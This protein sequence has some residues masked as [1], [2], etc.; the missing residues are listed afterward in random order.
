[1]MWVPRTPKRA[2]FCGCPP[3]PLCFCW[4]GGDKLM[5][6]MDKFASDLLGRD[7]NADEREILNRSAEKI[8]TGNLSRPVEIER[9]FREADE[10]RG[11]EMQMEYFLKQKRI[12]AA[13]PPPRKIDT[14]PTLDELGPEVFE[15]PKIPEVVFEF[16]RYITATDFGGRKNSSYVIWGDGAPDTRLSTTTKPEETKKPGKWDGGD[17]KKRADKAA[18]RARELSLRR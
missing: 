17:V 18:Q 5:D 14:R 15:K 2:D 1:M 6:G 13:R 11:N 16:T 8:H 9:Q 4:A 12:E 7:P 3:C 10:S